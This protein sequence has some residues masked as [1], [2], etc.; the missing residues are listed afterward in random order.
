VVPPAIRETAEFSTL[1][2]AGADVLMKRLA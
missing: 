1:G 2:P